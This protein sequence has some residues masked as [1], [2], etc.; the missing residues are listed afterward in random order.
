[1]KLRITFLAISLA[2]ML[3]ACQPTKENTDS[4]RKPRVVATT[5]M[6]YDVVL[7]ISGDSIDAQPLMGPGVDPH[8][9][10]ATQGDLKKLTEADLVLYNGLF[11]EGKMGEVFDKLSRIKPIVAVAETVPEAQLRNSTQYEDAYD[12]HIWFDVS[13]WKNAV[14]ET[15]RALQEIDPDNSEY[16]RTNTE[17]YLQ[18]LDTLHQWVK[19]RIAE[20]PE[21]QRILVTAHDAFGYFGDAYGIEVVGLQ[22]ISTLS[23]FGLKDISNLVDMITE[24]KIRAVFVETSVS[25]KAI[26]A[27][28]TGCREKGHDVVIGGNL[29][30]DAMGPFG[31]FEGTYIG[32]VTTNVNT[33]VEALK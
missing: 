13:L 1:M 23:E 6:I 28:V 26:N 7:N 29:F 32:M 11:L 16:Y 5:G 27:V 25:P 12:P 31:T 19:K 33:I 30:S 24:R 8:L 9:Y 15:N 3:W 22:G 4:N 10:K 2:A 18:Q 17:N 14:K 21:D 20:I